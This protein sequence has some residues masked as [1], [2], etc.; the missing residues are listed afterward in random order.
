MDSDTQDEKQGLCCAACQYE[1]MLPYSDKVSW[2]YDYRLKAKWPA[3]LEW[4]N[5]F[6]VEYVPMISHHTVKGLVGLDGEECSLKD[7]E[8]LCDL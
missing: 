2:H 4:H 6:D 3:A 8:N 5:D 1:H 7:E